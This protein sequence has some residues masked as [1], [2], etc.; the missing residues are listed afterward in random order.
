MKILIM[1]CTP[2]VAWWRDYIAK[3]MTV[4]TEDSRDYTVAVSKSK[5][6]KILKSD[7]E[8]IER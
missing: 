7:C 3:V 4:K 2:R 6:E 8:V 5:F 1:Q